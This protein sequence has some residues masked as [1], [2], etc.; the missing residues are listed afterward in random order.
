MSPLQC[1]QR[2]VAG[3]AI[4]RSFAPFVEELNCNKL[5]NIVGAGIGQCDI[6]LVGQSL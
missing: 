2:G 4:A 3:V 6:K 1:W 5:L